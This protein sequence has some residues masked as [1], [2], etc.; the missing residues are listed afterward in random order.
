MYIIHQP[1]VKSNYSVGGKD[2][3]KKFSI[4]IQEKCGFAAKVLIWED[5]A[6]QWGI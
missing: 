1:F 6:V 2:L 4:R 3:K 5:T